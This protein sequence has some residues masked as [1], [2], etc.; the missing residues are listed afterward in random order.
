L[1]GGL[2][3]TQAGK[4]QAGKHS[5]YIDKETTLLVQHLQML[6]ESFSAFVQRMIHEAAQARGMYVETT[7]TVIQK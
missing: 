1:A 5:V 6:D 4:T 2:V 7:M 3:Q